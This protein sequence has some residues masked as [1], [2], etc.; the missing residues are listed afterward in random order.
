VHT[1]RHTDKHTQRERE[2]ERDRQ[3]D[4]QTDRH[5]DSKD[6]KGKECICYNF[7]YLAEP[8]MLKITNNVPISKMTIVPINKIKREKER[9]LGKKEGDI[10]RSPNLIGST[11]HK[12]RT[13]FMISR[14]GNAVA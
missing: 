1:H 7:A 2:R 9:S 11:I 6:I 13:D 14:A 10:L 12:N 3:T 4:R 5:R 8:R